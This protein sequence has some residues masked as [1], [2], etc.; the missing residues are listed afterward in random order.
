MG[1]VGSPVLHQ[2][3]SLCHSLGVG[4]EYGYII[5]IF[6]CCKEALLACLNLRAFLN[7]SIKF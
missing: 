7:C 3:V 2:Y 4:Q 1:T 6:F 5:C